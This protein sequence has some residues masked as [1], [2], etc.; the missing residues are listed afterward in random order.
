MSGDYTV[1]A[2]AAHHAEAPLVDLS[3]D[4]VSLHLDGLT[5]EEGARLGRDLLA[6]AE[7]KRVPPRTRGIAV[8]M[9]TELAEVLGPKHAGHCQTWAQNLETVR[10]LATLRAAPPGEH[11]D[12]ETYELLVTVCVHPARVTSYVDG[13]KV[14]QRYVREG[15]EQRPHI[16]PAVAAAAELIEQR[17]QIGWITP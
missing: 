7:A 2:L 17:I 14:F 13:T 6:W 9:G 5:P 12:G 3:A 11:T 15:G 16:E 8:E 1:E 10:R 4:S